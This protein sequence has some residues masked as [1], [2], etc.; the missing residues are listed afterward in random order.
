MY[1]STTSAFP[2]APRSIIRVLVLLTLATTLFVAACGGSSSTG[3]SST[4]KEACYTDQA[5]LRFWTRNTVAIA[6]QVPTNSAVSDAE[7]NAAVTQKLN[8]ALEQAG[9][10]DL[11]A[12]VEQEAK[13]S[14]IQRGGA[15]AVAFYTLAS[16]DSSS[17]SAVCD[18]RVI[19]AVDTINQLFMPAPGQEATTLTPMVVQAEDANKTSISLLGASPDWIFTGRP[20]GGGFGHP[21]GP[22]RLIPGTFSSN[23]V[24]DNA[25]PTGKAP[26]GS[27]T[28]VVVLDTGYKL[29]KA[30]NP[31]S[32]PV[33]CG[34][35]VCVP[36]PQAITL[37]SQVATDF[38]NL[39]YSPF[40]G[41]ASAL[42]ESDMQVTTDAPD[43]GSPENG[44]PDEFVDNTSGT[45]VNIVDHGLFI[46]GQIHQAAPG[47]KIVLVRV[48]ND[49]GVGDLRSILTAVN[50]IANHP[51]QLGIDPSQQIVVNMSL[52]FGPSAA[53]LVGTY[54]QWLAIQKRDAQNNRP[55][56]FNCVTDQ[57]MEGA[58]SLV[59][60]GPAGKPGLYAA[61][62][63]PLSVALSQLAN[64][65]NATRENNKQA[66]I[67]AV[68]AS[69]GNESKGV[70]PA[71]DADLPA[72]ICGVIPVAA[73]SYAGGA[74]SPT[75]ADFSNNASLA[76]NQCLDI[77]VSSNSVTV[78]LKTETRPS[79]S[80]AGVNVCGI[81]L[82]AVPSA[83][84]DGTTSTGGPTA[85]NYM[86]LWNG[87]SFA[88]GWA[89][90]YI[91]RGGL[92][93]RSS[94]NVPDTQPC[95]LASS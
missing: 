61:L 81:F 56:D 10:G 30:A 86:A 67:T 69:A 59:A 35:D 13:Q 11:A 64:A 63:L 28:T 47:A 1:P 17:L 20:S 88:A 51:D 29:D 95:N 72:G 62:T 84:L 44:P 94:S 75:Q 80:A 21:S 60:G 34:T 41:L 66:P 4:T 24:Q 38:A 55:Y 14:P 23:N 42:V 79:V 89:S 70:S 73:L 85:P 53:C 2:S 6:L 82:Q 26:T 76:G 33:P 65:S 3:G 52:G 91:A 7:I 46:S 49:Y 58:T 18:Q 36:V 5:E 71:L 50:T 74:S 83:T 87:T 9:L 25:A 16:A 31:H 45:P 27:G 15:N 40:S 32:P 12:P 19:K 93:S 39:D 57:V 77:A 8:P 37:S 68:V 90:G 78:S 54:R 48:L 43:P 92:L 22:P